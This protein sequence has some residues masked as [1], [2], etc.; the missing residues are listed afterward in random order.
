MFVIV[1]GRPE[2]C[3]VRG[4]RL[5]KFHFL[6]CDMHLRC[7]KVKILKS[8]APHVKEITPPDDNDNWGIVYKTARA[9]DFK[10]NTVRLCDKHLTFRYSIVVSCK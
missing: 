7:Q 8:I 4:N 2:L 3:Y 5:K 1:I 6:L 9:I 10:N